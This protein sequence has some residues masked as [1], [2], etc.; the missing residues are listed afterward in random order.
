MTGLNAQ[1]AVLRNENWLLHGRILL[2]VLSVVG[3]HIVNK[4]YC[5]ISKRA[6]IV[7]KNELS[8]FPDTETGGVLLG[9]SKS[10]RD[11][12]ILEATDSGYQNV[13][14]EYGYFQ[15]DIAYEEH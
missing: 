5:F 11:I 2:F 8:R 4:M 6:Q 14:H 12:S 10:K 3:L 9:Y 15:Y 1:V 7:I 13:I